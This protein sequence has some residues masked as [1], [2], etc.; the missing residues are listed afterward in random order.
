VRQTLCDT[1]GRLGFQEEPVPAPVVFRR[2]RAV[3][4]ALVEVDR[5]SAVAPRRL[6]LADAEIVAAAS[7]EEEAS[8]F[9]RRRLERCP[10]EWTV[11]VPSGLFVGRGP[12]MVVLLHRYLPVAPAR[13]LELRRTPSGR[14]P[15]FAASLDGPRG[16]GLFVS[17]GVW[18]S[19]SDA[20]RRTR[21]RLAGQELP[22]HPTGGRAAERLWVSE[23]APARGG[24]LTLEM[25]PGV[26]PREAYPVT[27][28]S[29]RFADGRAR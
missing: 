17:V 27:L 24:R 2:G 12:A 26:G 15:T 13:A 14:R 20:P 1:P 18:L 28:Y 25:G 3:T 7:L 23:R 10:P 29:W 4:P 21:L 19:S 16:R 6:D 5:L 8:G 22:L 9:Y 11:P